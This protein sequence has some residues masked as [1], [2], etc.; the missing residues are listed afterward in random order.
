MRKY[1]RF[2]S[3]HSLQPMEKPTLEQICCR[4]AVCGGPMPEQGKQQRETAML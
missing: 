4:T 2:Y 1:C 3:R